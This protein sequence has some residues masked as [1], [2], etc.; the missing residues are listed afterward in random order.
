[1]RRDA[2]KL[3]ATMPRFVFFVG[4][5]MAMV[6]AAFLVTDALLGPTPGPTEANAR[7][8][9]AGMTLREA[10]IILGGPPTQRVSTVGKF[11]SSVGT[12]L[13]FWPGRQGGVLVSI[14][15]D[16]EVVEAAWLAEK[17]PP[18]LFQRVCS[19]LRF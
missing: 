6:A 8:V 19:W 4:V 7:K 16:N 14:R 12:A 5:A 17:A 13:L 15:Y 10:E 11:A 9:K 18:T 2:A 3:E 1:V